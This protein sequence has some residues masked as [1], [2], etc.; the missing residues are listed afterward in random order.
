MGFVSYLVVCVVIVDLVMSLAAWQ[1]LCVVII[2]IISFVLC[3]VVLCII[4]WFVAVVGSLMSLAV[5]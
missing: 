3:F 5:W 2:F 1:V 4:V